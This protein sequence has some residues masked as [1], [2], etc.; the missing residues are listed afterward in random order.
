MC[1]AS[2]ANS[3]SHYSMI[4][5]RTLNWGMIWLHLRVIIMILPKFYLMSRIIMMT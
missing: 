2:Y 1:C 3:F 4:D 5:D